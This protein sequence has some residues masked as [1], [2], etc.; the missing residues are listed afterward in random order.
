[1]EA[2]NSYWDHKSKGSQVCADVFVI[3]IHTPRA[4]YGYSNFTNSYNNLDSLN[5]LFQ[6]LI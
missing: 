1:M 5:F 6:F 3:K 2:K 4:G